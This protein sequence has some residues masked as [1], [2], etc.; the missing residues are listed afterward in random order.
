MENLRNDGVNVRF[1][2]G[3][4]LYHI[5]PLFPIPEARKVFKEVKNEI[6]R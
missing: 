2:T 4:G 5:Y 3:H 1:I 6:N